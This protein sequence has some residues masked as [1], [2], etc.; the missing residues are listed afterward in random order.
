MRLDL[1][2][3]NNKGVIDLQNGKSAFVC[4]HAPFM[5]WTEFIDDPDSQSLIV[6]GFD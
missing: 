5:Q 3:V 4:I 1:C 2:G 6:I